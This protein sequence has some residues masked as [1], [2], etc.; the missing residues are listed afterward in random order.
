MK[1]ITYH[2]LHASQTEALRSF[3]ISNERR[4]RMSRS[5]QRVENG[6]SDVPRSPR[7]KD[8]HCGPHCSRSCSAGLGE[9]RYALRD[10]ETR[11]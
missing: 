10:T 7:Q 1:A 3:G 5:K 9:M 2:R 4:H 8:A 6:G 11:G